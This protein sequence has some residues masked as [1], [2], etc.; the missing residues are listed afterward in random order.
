MP[1]ARFF[2]E[3][4]E[5]P[6]EVQGSRVTTPI[7]DFAL[8][9]VV[10]GEEVTVCVRPHGVRLVEAGTGIPG[11]LTSRRFL[12]EVELL[13]IVVEGLDEPLKARSRD[14][15]PIAVGAE[16]AVTIDEA[17]VLMFPARGD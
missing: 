8:Q 16:V 15:T 12:G 11:R 7:G 14:M 3:L 13:D 2:T 17:A 4:N 6:G 5:V 10:N 1:A 9:G